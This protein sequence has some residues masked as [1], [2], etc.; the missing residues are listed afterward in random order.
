MP[1]FLVLCLLSRFFYTLNDVFTGR[2]ARDHDR[3]ELAALR[4][5]SLGFSMAP[6]LFW[7][8]AAAWPKHP[9]LS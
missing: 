2:L 7:V 9:T 1:Q 3:L 4:G 8:P 5:I 6:L